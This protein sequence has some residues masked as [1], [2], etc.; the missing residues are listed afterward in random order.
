MKRVEDAKI[1]K[2]IDAR[3]E[4]AEEAINS[5]RPSTMKK[6]RQ[7]FTVFATIAHLSRPRSSLFKLLPRGRNDSRAE[8]SL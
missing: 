2:T 1:T 7:L 4:R 3:V 8:F 6:T 5:S